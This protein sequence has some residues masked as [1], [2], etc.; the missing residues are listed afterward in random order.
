[1]R[2]I[3]N[4][5]TGVS[6]TMEWLKLTPKI[7]S[8]FS[9]NF[10]SIDIDYLQYTCYK[11]SE[12]LK[13]LYN[14]LWFSWTIDTDNSNIEY[15]FNMN[16]SLVHNNT[17]MGHSYMITFLS[18][19]FAPLPIWS[20]E[21]YNP[22]RIKTL[23]TEWKIVFYWAYF[24]FKEILQEEA[25][26]FIRFANS[27]EFWTIVNTQKNQKPIYKRTRVDIAVDVWVS[28]SQK[29]LSKYIK[30]HKTSK[31]VPK[32]YN[33]QPQL[34]GWQSISYI[35]RLGQCIG[36]RVY[37]KILDI[38]SKNKQS[39]YP[40]YWT[41][42]NPIV[43]RIEIIYWWDSATWLLENLLEYTKY[44]ILW[45]NEEIRLVRNVKPK[46]VY[47]PIS[48]YKYFWRYAKN[49][50]KELLQ[51]IRDVCEVYTKFEENKN[52]EYEQV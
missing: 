29:W 10:I 50:W 11:I 51:V 1:M 38:H 5:K 4:K 45:D 43:T 22:N 20:I 13:N 47:S 19:W 52:L 35:P 7:Q 40:N 12:P 3:H 42:E 27:V 33:Y 48:A 37:N 14:V 32:P 17:K 24:R 26:E 44:R 49:H 18:P 9:K 25:P 39:W 30:P 21:V 8:E 36:I 34:W 16:L 23:W 15:N 31:H 46:S 6:R 28:L 41:E 2:K